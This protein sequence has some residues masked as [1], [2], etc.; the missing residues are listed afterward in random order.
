MNVYGEKQ[1]KRKQTKQKPLKKKVNYTNR[2]QKTKN[3]QTRKENNT[4]IHKKH[5]HDFGIVYYECS[6]TTKFEKVLNAAW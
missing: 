4:N 6:T 3:K 5:G 2:I 1:I